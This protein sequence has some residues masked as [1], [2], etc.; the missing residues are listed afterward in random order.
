VENH[1]AGETFMLAPLLFPWPRNAPHFF[2]SRI[3]TV[4]PVSHPLIRLIHISPNLPFVWNYSRNG[5]CPLDWT[6]N[7]MFY[8]NPLLQKNIH[9]NYVSKMLRCIGQPGL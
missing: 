3:A 6:S 8:T 7:P 4:T 1:H 5:N 2:H 9:M